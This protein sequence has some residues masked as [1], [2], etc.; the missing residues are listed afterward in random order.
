MSAHA[1]R[2]YRQTDP[3]T[4]DGRLLTDWRMDTVTATAGDHGPDMARHRRL[5]RRMVEAA[6]RA[7][8]AANT[9]DEYGRR[10]AAAEASRLRRIIAEG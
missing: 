3:G 8:A 9:G 10:Y 2:R 1:R 5:A 4:A 6:E 7:R